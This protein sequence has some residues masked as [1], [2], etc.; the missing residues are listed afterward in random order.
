VTVLPVTLDV[1]LDPV[2]M[3]TALE[4]DAREGLSSTPKTLPP[5]WFYDDVG[6]QLFDQ[7]TRLEEYYPTRAER[8]LLVDGAAEVA[9]ATGAATLVELGA[10]TCTKTRVLL[11]ALASAGT[12]RR[13]VAVDVA[14]GTLVAAT[15]EIA[16]EFPG[17]EVTAVV[18]DFQHL[19]GLFDQ[20]GPTL[21]AFLGGTI[22]NLEP[23]ER[24]RFLVGLDAELAHA[25]A[26]LLGTD[27]VKDRG[28]LLAAYDDRLGVT[29]AFNRNVLRVL[30]RELGADFDV[31]AFEHT[32]RFDEAQQWIEMRLRATS[33]QHVT[34]PGLGLELDFARG[35]ELRTE[36][37]AK[38]TPAR[39]T[40]ELSRS[41][42]VVERQFGADAGEFLLTLA[43]PY[44]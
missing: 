33:P 3:R 11:D 32:V 36:I 38:F 1:R 9:A 6:S 12:L 42:F 13:Y 20:G 37:S 35:E 40:E 23:D 21:V 27:L 39:I 43:H 2:A 41:G 22:G 10:G 28:R 18:A 34:V 8:A 29:A 7:I 44:C 15:G 30:N 24:G 25:D 19:Q 26:F 4:H 17:L 14:E 16:A 5:V 31:D